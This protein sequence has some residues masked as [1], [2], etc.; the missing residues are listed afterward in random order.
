MIEKPKRPW[1]NLE[2]ARKRVCVFFRGNKNQYPCLLCDASGGYHDPKDR[3]PMEGYKL[4]PRYKCKKCHGTGVGTK[5]ELVAHY[6]KEIADYKATLERYKYKIA[7]F[8]ELTVKLSEDD[9]KI[10]REGLYL[11][12]FYSD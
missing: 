11:S 2:D 7:R 12:C 6:K 3:D 1:K 10:L 5:E 9:L 8:N 4:A